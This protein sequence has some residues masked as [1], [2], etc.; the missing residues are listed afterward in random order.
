MVWIGFKFSFFLLPAFL[1]LRKSKG[2]FCCFSTMFIL[3]GFHY[4]IFPL[5]SFGDFD[6]LRLLL[7]C[8]LDSK[9]R[10]N[11]IIEK[12]ANFSNAST[13]N[14][15]AFS[16][17]NCYCLIVFSAKKIKNFLF[18]QKRKNLDCRL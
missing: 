8:D 2:F 5:N 16:F 18:F 11:Y 13:K 14:F 6:N 1:N 10:L 17:N 9:S 15:F 7:Y 12:A 3:F 4:E